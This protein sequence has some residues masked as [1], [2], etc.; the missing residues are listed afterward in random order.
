MF[1]SVS[2]LAPLLSEQLQG[3]KPNFQQKWCEV[4]KPPFVCSMSEPMVR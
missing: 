3:M 4:W 2:L 1:R